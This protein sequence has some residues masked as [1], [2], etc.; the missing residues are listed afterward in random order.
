MADKGELIMST[1]YTFDRDFTDKVHNKLACDLIYKSL[2]WLPQ[3]INAFLSQNVDMKN[4][5]DYFFIDV[6][7]N[8]IVT[9]QERFRDKQYAAYNDFT[10]RFEREYNPHE[11]RRLSEYYK[12]NA[13]YFVYG[14]IN[15]SKFEVD[16]AT[17]F[18]KFAVINIKELK[19]LMD[20]GD[21][22]IDRTLNSRCCKKVGAKM[23]CPVNYNKD[24]SSSFIP[25]DI[26]M[27]GELFKNVPIIISSK[28][29]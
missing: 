14:V 10:I 2:N 20:N 27:L 3:N 9:T 23:C 15:M 11:E 13:D 26:K 21:I 8:V 16:K 22:Y 25:I 12:L 5:V 19:R 1:N 6:N 7:R 4:A 17:D 18:I 29:Y 24:R 28:G